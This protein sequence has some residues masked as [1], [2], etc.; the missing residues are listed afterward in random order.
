M[1]WTRQQE[2]AIKQIVNWV[3]D[4]S[5]PQV[6]RLFGY[7]GTG[8]T[9]LAQEI[10]NIINGTVLFGA[11]TGKAA[12]V[13]R[14]KGCEEAQTIHSMIYTLV[15]EHEKEPKFV[16]NPDSNVRN[17][18]LVI[19]DECS[20]VGKEIGDDLLSFG[21]KILVLGDPAQLPPI[22]SEGYFTNDKPDVMLTEIHRQ[23][24]DNPIV[25]LAME[26]RAGR[27]L[28]E[29]S[30]GQSSIIPLESITD[31]IL[32]NADMVLV[33]RNK[34]RS[35]Y[36]NYFRSIKGFKTPYPEKGDKLVCLRN[37]RIKGLLNGSLWTVD[38]VLNSTQTSTRLKLLSDDGIENNRALDK[39]VMI[40]RYFFEGKE[41]E[42]DWA[43]RKRYDEFDYGYTLTVHKSQGSS[44][45]N[46][47]VVDESG[48]FRNM[49]NRWLYTA[50]TRASEKVTVLIP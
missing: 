46:V 2:K 5:A 4:S 16:L 40:H 7:A 41:S 44:W 33:G 9:T 23:A 26:V 25:Q 35:Q 6:F 34:V 28:S 39:G 36:N 27:Q 47:V 3:N 15:D 22:S 19:I 45:K 10:A 48:I 18:R 11:F 14:T 31:D 49:K 38:D 32:T 24:L 8:K 29:G 21:T 43:L 37:N 50:I 17:A 13:M 1:D 42:L 12:L 20:M 30:Y